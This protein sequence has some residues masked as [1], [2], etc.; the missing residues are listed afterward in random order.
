M[1]RLAERVSARFP[2]TCRSPVARR[3]A[4]MAARC[5]FTGKSSTAAF[6]RGDRECLSCQ[7][8]ASP[9]VFVSMPPI[10]FVA[11]RRAPGATS[12]LARRAGKTCATMRRVAMPS[13]SCMRGECRGVYAGA[14]AFAFVETYAAR[15]GSLG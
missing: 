7:L 1:R 4:I 10:A 8:P 15:S 14:D 3:A 2:R 12:A 11:S 9:A 5:A 13:A 6:Q